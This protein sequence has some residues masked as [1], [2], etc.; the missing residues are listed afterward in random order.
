MLR[1][2]TNS[3]SALTAGDFSIQI[4]TLGWIASGGVGGLTGRQEEIK[5]AYGY[6]K[7]YYSKH[8]LA[9]VEVPGRSSSCL[10]YP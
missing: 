5:L 7:Y 9:L 10:I 4:R 2:S 3:E 8:K 1:Q 6:D